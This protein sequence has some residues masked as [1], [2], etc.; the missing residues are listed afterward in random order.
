[1]EIDLLQAEEAGAK[2]RK[3]FVKERLEES[4]KF[5]DPVT[6]LNLKTMAQTEENKGYINKEQT[7]S[8]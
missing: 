7:I 2:A 6:R 5:F 3:I 8:I 4:D 1:M